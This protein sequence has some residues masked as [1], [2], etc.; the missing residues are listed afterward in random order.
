VIEE[1]LNL[2]FS[3]K[4]DR[5]KRKYSVAIFHSCVRLSNRLKRANRSQKEKAKNSLHYPQLL[6]FLARSWQGYR[7]VRK[8]VKKRVFR[9]M[10]S[11]GYRSMREYL[12]Q[13]ERSAKD[14]F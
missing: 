8:A 7:K 11:V 2:I 12:E 14:S 6:E 5:V 10:Q 13:L 1:S 4:A 3:K 9:H